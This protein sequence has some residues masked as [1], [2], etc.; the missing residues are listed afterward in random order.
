MPLP[1]L[2]QD[3]SDG[4]QLSTAEGVV[5]EL[6]DLVTF[7]AGEV[8]DWDQ[9]RAL[10][11]PETV[12]VLRTSR[13]G[14]TVMGMDG[15]IG[16]W[17]RDI[18]GFGMD[19]TGFSETIVRMHTTEFGDIAHIWVLYEAHIPGSERPPQQGVDSIQLVRRDGQWLIASITNELPTPD[20]P[21]PEV[22]REGG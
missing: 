7:P 11:L 15:F 16:L 3:E 22:L 14:N 13:T 4:N 19:E 20:R 2:G 17:L 8:P 5:R 18:E 10:F 21:I 12:I 1:A 6:Y 9:M